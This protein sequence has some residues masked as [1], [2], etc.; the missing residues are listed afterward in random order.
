V[1]A[2]FRS[3]DALQDEMDEVFGDNSGSADRERMQE[4]MAQVGL[5]PT[6]AQ[7]DDMVQDAKDAVKEHVEKA[8]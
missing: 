6:S 1:G 3:R 8:V 4:I 7:L 2:I 5:E